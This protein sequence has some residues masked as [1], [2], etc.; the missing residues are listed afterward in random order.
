VARMSKV[1]P[2][3]AR[4]RK[5]RRHHT[6]ACIDHGTIVASGGA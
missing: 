3:S 6:G 1:N 4:W 2:T 5:T